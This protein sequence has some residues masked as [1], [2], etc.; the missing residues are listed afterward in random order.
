MR[1]KRVRKEHPPLSPHASGRASSPGQTQKG[2]GQT[3]EGEGRPWRS[4][5][6]SPVAM[7]TRPQPPQLPLG[8]VSVE[9]S[10]LTHLGQ[11]SDAVRKQQGPVEPPPSLE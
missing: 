6:S 1:G 2:E 5:T 9:R 4:C 7:E 11:D 8:L 10:L 3:L